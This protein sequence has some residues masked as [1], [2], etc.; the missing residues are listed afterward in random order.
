MLSSASLAASV[1]SSDSLR[2]SRVM[3]IP[4][5]AKKRCG[6]AAAPGIGHRALKLWPANAALSRH[7]LAQAKACGERRR[8]LDGGATA[9][10]ITLREMTVAGREQGAGD[11]H[12][13]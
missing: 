13:Q 2:S 7:T 4:V 5:V 12:R 6:N 10:P 3:G 11:V 1:T 9:L 8:Y